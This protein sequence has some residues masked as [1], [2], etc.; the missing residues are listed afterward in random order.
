[1]AKY[2][3]D[4]LLQEDRK[5]LSVVLT[6]CHF[7]HSGGVHQFSERGDDCYIHDAELK[8]VL[9]QSSSLD[10][11]AW[12][13]DDEVLPKPRVG[14]SAKD[15]LVRGCANDQIKGLRG[16]EKIDLGDRSFE[17]KTSMHRTC[18]IVT[19]A[20]SMQ[21][22]HLPG[23]TAGSMGLFDSWN[24]ILVTG[25]AL[26][27]TE[28]QLIDWYPPGSS[29]RLMA[30]SLETLLGL[31]ALLR[32]AI[33]FNLLCVVSMLQAWPR[34]WTSCCLATTTSWKAPSLSFVTPRGT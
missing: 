25:D 27:A 30:N 24:G 14:W 12:I 8:A 10:T 3:K 9:R 33:L 20:V 5:P 32:V 26:Y 31:S 18:Q 2:V 21:V 7:D 15:Y 11:C 34:T 17:V 6:H 16:G 23:H 22:L 4:V 19:C 13:T 28:E 1:M 29:V